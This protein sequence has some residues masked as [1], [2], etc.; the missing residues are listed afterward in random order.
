MKI[1]HVIKGLVFTLSLGPGRF[2]HRRHPFSM[3]P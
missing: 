3:T 1:R 2:R